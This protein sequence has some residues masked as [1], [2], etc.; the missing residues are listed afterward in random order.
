MSSM[1]SFMYCFYS[2]GSTIYLVFIRQFHLREIVRIKA[3]EIVV[4]CLGTHVMYNVL[5]NEL[6]TPPSWLSTR[7]SSNKSMRLQRYDRIPSRE[8][9]VNHCRVIPP[10]YV[11]FNIFF[12]LPE[13]LFLISVYFLLMRQKFFLVTKPLSETK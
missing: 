1:L 5:C 12:L 7:C 3:A 4:I 10:F 2:A 6:T 13:D 9:H 8:D 11:F